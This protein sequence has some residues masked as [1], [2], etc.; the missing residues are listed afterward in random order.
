M[1]NWTPPKLPP[2]LTLAQAIAR[3]EGF[4]AQGPRPNR[5]QRNHNPGDIEYDDFSRAH[6][7]IGTDGRF[8]I[9]PDD[10]TGFA[11]LN[12]LLQGKHYAGLTVE[13]AINRYAPP[14]ENND[15]SYVAEVCAWTGHEPTDLVSEVL[16]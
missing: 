1:M 7:A 3:V 13:A 12:A 9:F 6:G 2:R 16:A 10:A 5:P 8:A 15:Q 14:N 11:A 4:Y